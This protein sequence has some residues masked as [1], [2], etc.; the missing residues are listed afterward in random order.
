M[1]TPETSSVHSLEPS[2][3]CTV[4]SPPALNEAWQALQ[5]FAIGEQ[6]D[7]PAPVLHPAV[8]KAC[9]L[10]DVAQMNGNMA[11]LRRASFAL[12]RAAG[13][14]AA[15]HTKA[16][17]KQKKHLL[18][19]RNAAVAAQTRWDAE[20]ASL[21]EEI[22]SLRTRLTAARLDAQGSRSALEVSEA[23]VAELLQRL[24]RQEQDVHQAGGAAAAARQRAEASVQE[25]EVQAGMARAQA[26]QRR[27]A[28]EQ[29]ERANEQLSDM[30]MRLRNT[31]AQLATARAELMERT[32]A[33]ERLQARMA[34]RNV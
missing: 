14:A 34:D 32:N 20:R 4:A 22:T 12:V 21:L 9:A 18:Q 7:E 24:S 25:A 33:L 28:S 1:S 6:R 29:C 3:I 30:R 10:I 27:S 5:Q 31:E 16:H 23:K 13:M 2:L 19:E 11:G 8:A 17:R 26:E 15:D